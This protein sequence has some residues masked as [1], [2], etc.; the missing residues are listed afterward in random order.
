MAISQKDKKSADDSGLFREIANK[1][2]WALSELYDRHSPR[3][4]GL[5][6][7]IL[8]RSALAE[9]V[10]QDLFVYLWQNADVMQEVTTGLALSVPTEAPPAAVKQ[11][12]FDAI[13]GPGK[14]PATAPTRTER[15]ASQS[16]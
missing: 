9:D 10:L 6:L 3:L 7:K 16:A 11:R 8:K 4:Y 1:Q 2:S 12:I 15:L 13:E 14:S 5:A